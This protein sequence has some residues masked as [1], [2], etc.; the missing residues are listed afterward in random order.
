[1]IG[2]R[3]LTNCAEC[4]AKRRSSSLFTVKKSRSACRLGRF[5][6]MLTGLSVKKP[7][8]DTFIDW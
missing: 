2:A 3:N 6:L 4:R 7:P 8:A 1:M 5:S